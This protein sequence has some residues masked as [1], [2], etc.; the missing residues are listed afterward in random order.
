MSRFCDPVQTLTVA[1]NMLDEDDSPL[2]K[3]KAEDQLSADGVKKLKT[4]PSS[5]PAGK[6][7]VV[8]GKAQV[9]NQKPARKPATKARAPSPSSGGSDDDGSDDDSDDDDD[10]S[11]ES[12]NSS[13]SDDSGDSDDDDKPLIS[14]R[15]KT[16]AKPAASSAKKPAKQPAKKPA[17]RKKKA[18]DSDDDDESGSD[19]E[20]QRRARN[21]R[22]TPVLSAANYPVT[23]QVRE[24]EG[25]ALN[26]WWN[27]IDQDTDDVKWHTLQHNGV[28]LPPPYQPHGVKLV[29]E[30]KSIEM[31]P[32]Q[33]ELASFYAA[34]LDTQHAENPIFNKN[35][36]EAFQKAMHKVCVLL[37]KVTLVELTHTISLPADPSWQGRDQV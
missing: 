12:E 25:T 16:A 11:D 30:G 7:Q 15:A 32:E 19:A 1:P 27:R 6:A 20:Q 3:R 31:N 2:V 10:S 37:L 26:K 13:S 17:A 22:Q 24:L 14:A 23:S 8:R 9:V 35:F 29:Y 18:D 34:K 4:E 21:S 33:E 5:A 28:L 36:F